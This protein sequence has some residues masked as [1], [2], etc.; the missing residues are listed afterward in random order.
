MVHRA[1]Q[2]DQFLMDDADKLVRG[3]EG[4]EDRLADGLFGDLGDEILGD[5][6]ADVGFQQGPLDQGQPFA[7]VRLGQP[8]A[9]A[10]GLDR[11][12]E[13]FLKGFEHGYKGSVTAARS[14]RRTAAS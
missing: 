10:E 11:R 1:H 4:L 6:D 8:A 9:A 7:H 13:V 5:L 12:T 14:N 3:V 2:V